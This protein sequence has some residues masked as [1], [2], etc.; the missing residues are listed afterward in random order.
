MVRTAEQ[1][2]APKERLLR[3]VGNEACVRAD[4]EVP[5]SPGGSDNDA[6]DFCN[7]GVMVRRA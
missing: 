3:E 7:C 1:I 4:R 2:A 6:A 5:D